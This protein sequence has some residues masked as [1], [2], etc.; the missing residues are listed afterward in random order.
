MLVTNS[1]WTI[2]LS[3]KY[4]NACLNRI[5]LNGKQEMKNLSLFNFILTVGPSM[6]VSYKPEIWSPWLKSIFQLP[7][8]LQSICLSGK[9]SQIF[10][11]GILQPAGLCRSY[12]CVCFM[13]FTDWLPADAIYYLAI[14]RQICHFFVIFLVQTIIMNTFPEASST[15][16]Q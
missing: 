1:R 7:G 16:C 11:P 15:N 3:H 14:F 12:L 10:I 9:Q 8:S 13:Y 6:Q 5:I 4:F 2:L